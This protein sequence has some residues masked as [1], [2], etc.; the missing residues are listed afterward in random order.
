M[1][2]AE[3]ERVGALATKERATLVWMTKIP[4]IGH[5]AS[6]AYAAPPWLNSIV[7]VIE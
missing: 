1:K 4:G 3:E 5:A 7:K 2:T 6:A